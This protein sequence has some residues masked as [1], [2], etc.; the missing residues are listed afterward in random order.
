MLMLKQTNHGILL[1]VKVIP[2][3]SRTALVGWENDELKIRLAAVPDKG[4]ANDALIQFLSKFLEIGKSHIT[5]IQGQTSRH[6][7]LCV[8]G[9]TLSQLQEKLS[10]SKC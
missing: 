5:I 3:A 7:R 1:N 2:K 8:T 10:I 9:L 6:K 4:E